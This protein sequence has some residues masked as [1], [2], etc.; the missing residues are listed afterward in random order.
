M[1]KITK[2]APPVI[3]SKN[4]SDYKL[5]KRHQRVLQAWDEM[6]AYMKLAGKTPPCVRLTRADYA[7]IN[8]SVRNQSDNKRDLSMVTHKG[9]PIYSTEASPQMDVFA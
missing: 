1:T 8:A 6:R 5:T 4:L 7:G 2:P 3:L 9:V